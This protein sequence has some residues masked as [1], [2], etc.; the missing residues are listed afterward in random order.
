MIKFGMGNTLITFIDRYYE[1]GG[2]ENI[3]EWGLT[4]G[5]YESA[6]LADLVASYILD[7]TKILFKDTTLHHSI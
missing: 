6:W 2:S 4:V 3:N 5:G 7:N 1:Y